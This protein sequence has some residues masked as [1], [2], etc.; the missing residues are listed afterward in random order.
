M[1]RPHPEEPLVPHGSLAEAA[2]RTYVTLAASREVPRILVGATAETMAAL[3]DAIVPGDVHWP[4]AS[5][6]DVVGYV[7][8]VLTRAPALADEFVAALAQLAELSLVH[9]GRPLP[10]LTADEREDVVR[11][12]EAV[13]PLF[14]SFV[15]LCYEAYYRDPRV[16]EVLRVR[17]G[18]RVEQPLTGVEL[19][20]FDESM[21]DRVRGL[22]P[23][24]RED[25]R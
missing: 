2:G 18:F 16:V 21:L 24:Y 9:T 4:P 25:P 15:E 10:A 22:P 11:R 5:A 6:T 13:Q 8:A 20:A 1:P 14:R 3:C 23:R 17:T 19:P 12:F 7:D